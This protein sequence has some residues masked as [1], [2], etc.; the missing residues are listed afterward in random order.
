MESI[1]PQR[2]I[3]EAGYYWNKYSGRKL[4]LAA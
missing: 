2:M 4:R 3:S 1:S